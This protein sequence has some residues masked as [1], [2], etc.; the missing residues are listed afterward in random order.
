MTSEIF[1]ILA[2]FTRPET[3]GT[4]PASM[5]WMF[6]LLASIAAVY[7]ATKLPVIFWKRFFKETI[8]LFA[9]IS[10]FMVLIAVAL[11]IIVWI[12]TA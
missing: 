12:L 9:T 1:S 2:T 4:T 10:V 11:H 5:L 7:K 3:I 8:I 6:P